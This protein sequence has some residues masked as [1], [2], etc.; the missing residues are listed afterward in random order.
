MDG[1]PP[2]TGRRILVV[3][4]ETLASHTLHDVVRSHVADVRTAR[5]LAVAPAPNNRCGLGVADGGEAARTAAVRRLQACVD[6]LS[7]AGIDIDGLLGDA[8]PLLATRDALRIF[9]ADLLIVATRPEGSSGRVAVD[10]V[11]RARREFGLPVTHVVVE[12]I[13]GR[14]S[15]GGALAA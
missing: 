6:A 2:P 4:A 8:D 1:T 10:L 3:A 14:A 7:E 11:G 9:P 15:R 5:V 13:V 12:T